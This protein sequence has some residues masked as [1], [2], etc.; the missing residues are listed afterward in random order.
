MAWPTTSH[1]TN[2][3]AQSDLLNVLVTSGYTPNAALDLTSVLFSAVANLLQSFP[4]VGGPARVYTAVL[5]PAQVN[6]NTS[7]EQI[8]A[9]TGVTTADVVH[10]NKPTAQA[11]IGIVGTRV[12]SNGNVGITFGNF[13]GGGITPTASQTYSFT[14]FRA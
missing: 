2:V 12:S 4:S 11:G 1:A 13:T 6:A 10:V 8:F 3:A 9:V 14:A 5:S 7:A